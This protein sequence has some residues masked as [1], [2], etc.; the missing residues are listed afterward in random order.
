M[1]RIVP[2]ER[3]ERHSPARTRLQG[4]EPVLYLR[5]QPH[6]VIFRDPG[7]TIEIYSRPKSQG[8]LQRMGPEAFRLSPIRATGFIRRIGLVR[9]FSLAG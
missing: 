9:Q 2:G 8:G 3:D 7:D 1:A 6:R 5:T 4:M